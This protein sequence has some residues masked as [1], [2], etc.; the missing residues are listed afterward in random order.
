VKPEGWACLVLAALLAAPAQAVRIGSVRLAAPIHAGG[1][2]A[3]GFGVRSRDGLTLAPGPG[4]RSACHLPASAVPSAAFII[5]R[6]PRLFAVESP[7]AAKVAVASESRLLPASGSSDS[8]SAAALEALDHLAADLAAAQVSG[9]ALGPVFRRF[10]DRTDMRGPP[11]EVERRLPAES[12]S[13]LTRRVPDAVL[14]DW[15][16]TIVDERTTVDAIRRRLFRELGVPT[17]SLEEAERVWRA[18]H[19]EFFSRFFPGVPREVVLQTYYAIMDKLSREKA[20]RGQPLNKPM[21]GAVKLLKA[22]KRRGIALAVVS[23]KPQARLLGELEALGLSDLFQYVQGDAPGR[24]LKPSAQP[25]NEAMKAMGLEPGHVWYVGDEIGDM[26]A[27]RAAGLQGIYLGTRDQDE[28]L[29]RF[30]RD[31][32]QA[33]IVVDGF[34]DLLVSIVNKLPAPARR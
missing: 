3:A 33:V 8:R 32:A 1:P 28:L 18:D 31:G 6:P 15:D 25:I 22:L 20:R 23:N 7:A 13:R 24:E 4:L 17:P 27:A 10:F 21:P 2:G 14:F 12:I 5:A 29:R 11:A 34:R 16:N 9:D 30:G 26:T 19:D